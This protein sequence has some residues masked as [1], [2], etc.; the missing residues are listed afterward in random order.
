[1]LKFRD[2]ISSRGTRGI[3]SIR[4]NFMI[5]DDDNSRKIDYNEFHKFCYD[6]R[7][8]LT[9]P[10]VKKLFGIF[11]KDNSG[12]IDY[13]EFINGIVGEMNDRRMG[14][15]K[16]AFDKMDKNNNGVIEIDD[17]K[18]VYTAK[19]HP[20]VLSGKKCE[21]EILAEFLDTFEY[22]FSLLNDKKT[23][24]R[25]IT[26]EEFIE[27]YNNISMSIDDDQYFEVMITNAWNIDNKPNYGKGW[28]S[29][30]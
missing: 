19:S 25:T 22:H 2:K 9:D 1:M 28:R 8:E 3:M 26:L 12:C 23:K 6:F 4:R 17:L 24:D 11:D 20:D 21:E 10:E 18:G 27:Y 13:D 29:D 16:K 5:A 7:M 15:V 30:H 14:I